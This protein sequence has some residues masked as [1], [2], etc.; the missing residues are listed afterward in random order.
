MLRKIDGMYPDNGFTWGKE[1][2]H[3]P[4][5]YRYRKKQEEWKRKNAQPWF[6]SIEGDRHRRRLAHPMAEIQ[7]KLQDSGLLN[8]TDTTV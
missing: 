2:G 8:C 5:A 4:V 7:T 6:Q 3:G 1:K